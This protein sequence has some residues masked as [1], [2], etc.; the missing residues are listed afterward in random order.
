MFTGTASAR[1][2]LGGT[3]G[4]PRAVGDLKVDTGSVL[5]PFA[6]F[7]VQ[8]GTVRLRES[9]PFHARVSLVALSQR[10]DYQLRLSVTGN[11]PTP[12]VTFT[13]SPAL[14]SSD[15]VMM[16]MAGRP[17][18]ES[19]GTSTSQR[20]AALGAY[21]GRSVFDELGFGGGEDRLEFTSGEEVSRQ[22]R[23]TYGIEYKLRDRWSV[24]GEYDQFDS[25]NADVKYRIYSQESHP[26]E[27]K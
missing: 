4:E 12:V 15:L 11:L 3:L 27:K 19:T 13:S 7:K 18:A 23:E 5:F 10:R 24:E 22:G 17:P 2:H 8:E 14:D 20:A 9:D 21:L 26:R 6:T 16:V 1:F 25:Y